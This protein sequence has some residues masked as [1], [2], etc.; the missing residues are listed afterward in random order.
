[1]KAANIL[2]TEEGH[3]KLGDFGVASQTRSKLRRGSIVGSPYWMAPEVIKQ[4]GYN[5]KADIWSFGIAMIELLTGN[6]P[7]AHLGPSSAV[8]I[9]SKSR[10]IPKLEG[11]FSQEA[12][13]FVNQCFQEY[14]EKV[15]RI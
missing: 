11:N 2:V 7:L 12:K 4:N 6:P 14:P 13:T 15:I 1:M 3:I 8:D 10:Y 5:T 9:I